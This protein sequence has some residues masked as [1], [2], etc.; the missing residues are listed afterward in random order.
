MRTKLIFIALIIISITSC[1]NSEDQIINFIEKNNPPIEELYNSEILYTE[2]GVLKVK[3]ISS[4][5]ERK[6][7]D[8]EVIYLS[9]GIEFYFYKLDS[10]NS[11]TLLTCNNA[12]INNNIMKAINN[13]VLKSPDNKTLKSEELIWDK[14]KDIIYSDLDV[15]VITDNE[16]VTGVG[17]KSTS[18]FKEY[19]IMKAKGVF[20][21]NLDHES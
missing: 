21:I 6:S 17:F 19:E 20:N 1:E 12:V 13:V 18:D 8:S 10:L 2:N 7:E 11:N 14:E 5:M 4:K 16:I 3:V 15:E 9:G